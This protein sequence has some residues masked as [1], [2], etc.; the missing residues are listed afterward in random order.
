ML[1]FSPKEIPSFHPRGAKSFALTH[2]NPFPTNPKV[3]LILEVRGPLYRDYCSFPRC[4]R[5][6]REGQCSSNLLRT[7]ISPVCSIWLCKHTQD[8]GL[9]GVGLLNGQS[10]SSNKYLHRDGPVKLG[11]LRA[12]PS[13]PTICR[14]DRHRN[15]FCIV[16]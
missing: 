2:R 16:S 8:K 1:Y 13:L 15:S 4:P 10:R 14:E 11:C 12:A 9:R 3:V 6:G 7:D 5:P